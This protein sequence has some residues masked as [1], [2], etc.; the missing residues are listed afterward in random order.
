MAA[1][2]L[3]C[4]NCGAAASSEAT[5][6]EHCNSRLATVA[7]PSCFGMIFRGAKFCSHC[8]MV[9]QRVETRANAVCPCPR[10][11]VNTREITLGPSRLRECPVCEGLWVDSVALHQI[12]TDRERQATIL[13]DAAD[14]VSA[15]QLAPER[16][17]YVPCPICKQLMHRVNFAKC[18][19]VIVDVCKP[20][21]TWFDRD[22]LH[23]IVKFISTG[24]MDVARAK[25]AEALDQKR[26]ELEAVRNAGA[27][28]DRH[29]G[30][31]YEYGTRE[32]A[33]TMALGALVGSFF[34]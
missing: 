2:S 10:C 28:T 15:A 16:V 19:N 5:R 17:R 33:I 6:C 13:G 1:Q 20:H 8:G 34:D 11:R 7:C 27:A 21:G 32:N 31:Q 12:C 23:R 24:G 9:V 25:E 3:N 4:P 22:E 29:A 26:R 18:S 14:V 30:N